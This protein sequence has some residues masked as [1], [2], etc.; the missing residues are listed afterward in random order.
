MEK[1]IHFRRERPIFRNANHDLIVAIL[2][3][4]IANLEFSR[5]VIDGRFDNGFPARMMPQRD[6]ALF[7]QRA[8]DETEPAIPGASQQ[9][10]R[11]TWIGDPFSRSVEIENRITSPS[12]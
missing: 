7:Q 5:H 4:V 9:T 8:L 2:H 11:S 6:G 12:S 1:R 10:L 3:Q